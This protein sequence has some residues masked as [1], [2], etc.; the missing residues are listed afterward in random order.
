LKSYPRFKVDKKAQGPVAPKIFSYLKNPCHDKPLST[1]VQF[2][3]E[4]LL[5]RGE[6]VGMI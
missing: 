1:K 5:E 6:K 4:L 2:P 3:K